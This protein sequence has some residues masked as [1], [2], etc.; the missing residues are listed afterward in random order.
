[1]GRG[2]GS[3]EYA[4]FRCCD[5][6]SS[7]LILAMPTRELRIANREWVEAVATYFGL[8]SP[9]F[10]AHVGKP[11]AGTSAVVD[12]YTPVF[13]NETS[14]INRGGVRAR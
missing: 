13:F 10:A 14:L 4:A 1:M 8:P 6:F 11:V 12:E 5:R 9:A 2:A 7:Q 3:M